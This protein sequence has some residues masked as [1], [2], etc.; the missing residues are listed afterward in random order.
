MKPEPLPRKLT[1]GV[2]GGLLSLLLLAL[3]S[4]PAP[5]ATTAPRPNIVLIFADDLGWQET[6]FSGSD[7]LETPRLDQLAREGMMFR[8][9]YASA[10]NCQPS[11]ACML[12]GQY[13]A[14]HGVYAVGSTDRGPKALM[15]MVPVPNRP[16]LP[17]ETVTLGESM[18]AAGYATGFFGKCHMNDSKTGKSEH[19]G[20][21]VIRHSQHG[22]NSDDPTDPKAIFSITRAA[23]EFIEAN[24][25]RPF[26][27]YIPHYAVHARLEGRANTLAHFKNKAPGKLGHENNLLAACLSDLDTGIGMVLDKLKALDLERNTL[28]V[29]TSD[30]GG[31]HVSNEPLRGKKGG[32]YE[33]GIRVPMIVRWPG[34]VAPGSI[35][36]VPVSNVDFYPTFL[37]AIGAPAPRSPL[38]G[39]S[40]LPLFK[41]QGGLKRQ[42][43]FWHFPGYL[44]DPV[45]RGRDPV[46]RT[47]PVSV[48]RQGNLKL[49]LYHEEWQLD[50]GRPGL[51]TNRAVELY[52]LATDPGE[53][54]DL[55]AV[56][57]QERDALLDALLAWMKQT[58]APL[59][60]QINPDYNPK[61]QTKAGK[62]KTGGK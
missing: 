56:R 19:A 13:T 28:V 53:H 48:I 8:H 58:G 43:L 49:H 24:R 6:G 11:R 35:C 38:D 46:F 15:R 62:K 61:S 18:K 3:D 37:D 39:E 45:P 57:I 50:G 51:A 1:S 40:L 23:C 2:R 12:S 16:N 32:Y 60:Q 42:S 7:F 25:G 36:D 55:A 52:D 14:R 34:V 9:A 21:E 59:P 31:T 27:A 47:R 29:F 44:D 26:F 20:F 10:G 41:N 54:T 33:G 5:A 30:N 4:G 22:L 17:P